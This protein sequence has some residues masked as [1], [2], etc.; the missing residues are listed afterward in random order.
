MTP[1][2]EKALVIFH[3]LRCGTKLLGRSFM[4]YINRRIGGSKSK[5]FGNGAGVESVEPRRKRGRS[6]SASQS[7]NDIESMKEVVNYATTQWSRSIAGYCG[8][9]THVPTTRKRGGD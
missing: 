1:D 4:D 9:T 6:H 2:V 7:E 5:C 3:V 8:I